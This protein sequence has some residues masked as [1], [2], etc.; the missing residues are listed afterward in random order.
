M[1]QLKIFKHNKPSGCAIIHLYSSTKVF[2]SDWK[3]V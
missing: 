1:Q 3:V 2:K